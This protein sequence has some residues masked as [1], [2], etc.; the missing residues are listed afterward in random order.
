MWQS[1]GLCH[2]LEG[3]TWRFFRRAAGNGRAQLMGKW[4]LIVR[5][6][7]NGVTFYRRRKDLFA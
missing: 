7:E 5:R 6:R 4:E 3:I 1:E 2:M